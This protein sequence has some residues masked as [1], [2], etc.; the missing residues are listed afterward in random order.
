[1]ANTY[2]QIVVDICL[3]PISYVYSLDV[4]ILKPD[5]TTCT[6]K[7]SYTYNIEANYGVE[8]GYTQFK[9][10]PD[11]GVV[12]RTS[13]VTTSTATAATTADVAVDPAAAAVDCNFCRNTALGR[14][15]ENKCKKNVERCKLRGQNTKKCIDNK[16]ELYRDC[17]KPDGS[18]TCSINK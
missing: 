14:K 7:A 16:L 12:S 13:P 5:G 4:K 1:M 6:D 9:V 17:C 8:K 2:K 3:E 10:K 11:P 18:K 15:Y